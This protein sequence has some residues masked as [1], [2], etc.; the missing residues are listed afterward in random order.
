M[1]VTSSRLIL[2]LLSLFCVFSFT[3]SDETATAT[4][5]AIA[6]DDAAA[7]EDVVVDPD[8]DNDD[9]DFDVTDLLPGLENVD[10]DSFVK[11]Y[12]MGNPEWYQK[13]FD[14]VSTMLY[15]YIYINYE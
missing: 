12:I 11:N 5:D 9:G 8:A 1:R 13:P 14:P 6:V 3:L 4:D 15:I 10:S 2:V 7:S